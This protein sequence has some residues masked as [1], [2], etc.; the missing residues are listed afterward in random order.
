MK[1]SCIRVRC[2]RFVFNLLIG[3]RCG[4]NKCPSYW[5]SQW[6]HNYSSALP[7]HTSSVIPTGKLVQVKVNPDIRPQSIIFVL[8]HHSTM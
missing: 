4:Q 3:T 6:G 8:R 2:K 5:R 1:E 7:G